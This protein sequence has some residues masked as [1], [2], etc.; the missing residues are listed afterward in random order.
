MSWKF[1][2]IRSPSITD[3]TS[4]VHHKFPVP[5]FL[6]IAAKK[7][8]QINQ[9]ITVNSSMNAPTGVS[10]RLHKKNNSCTPCVPLFVPWA[11]LGNIGPWSF[12]YSALGP[13]CYDLWPSSPAR[14]SRSV[15]KRLIF[16]LSVFKHI[17]H[18]QGFLFSPFILILFANF[19]KYQDFQLN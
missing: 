10:P 17:F 2:V 18:L 5:I 14:P 6:Y 19:F 4:Y 12:L 9:S 7:N 8:C 1:H 11:L 15:S 3:V 13:Y 16:V